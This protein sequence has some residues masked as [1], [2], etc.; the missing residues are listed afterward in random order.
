MHIKSMKPYTLSAESTLESCPMTF[1][2]GR[3][4]GTTCVQA[5]P[6]LKKEAHGTS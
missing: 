2:I 1:H 3:S 6:H 5:K 4:Q